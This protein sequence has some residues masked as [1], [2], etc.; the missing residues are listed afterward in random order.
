MEAARCRLTQR[1]IQKFKVYE[2]DQIIIFVGQD[3]HFLIKKKLFFLFKSCLSC[4]NFVAKTQK[5]KITFAISHFWMTFI[6]N[7][8]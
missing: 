4:T 8:S 6:L 7:F 1:K 5:S 3:M 2:R